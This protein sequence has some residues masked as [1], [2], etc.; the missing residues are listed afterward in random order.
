MPYIR[1]GMNGRAATVDWSAFDA[2]LFDLDG[3]LTPTATTHERAWTAMFD[4]F[5]AE[6]ADGQAWDP[7][8]PDDYLRYVDGKPRFDGVRSFVES[9]RIP[10]REGTHD[11]P[12]GYG[13]IGALG[14]MKNDAFQRIL[15]TEGIQPF[16]G[17]VLVLDALELRGVAMAV[18]SS[19]KNAPEVLEASGLASRFGVVV[20]GTAATQLGLPGKPAPDTYLAAAAQLEVPAGRAVVAEDAISGVAAGRAGQFGLVIG[21]DRGAGHADLLDNGAD[22]VVDDL[23]E[24]LDSLAVNT[25]RSQDGNG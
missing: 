7:F 17:S 11:D 12:P 14:N 9:R 5:L 18:V 3:V 23:A 4:A 21:V 13:S 16:P 10:L 20:D 1:D 22:L 2:V 8:S 24:L 25:A 15:R 6:R 19:S